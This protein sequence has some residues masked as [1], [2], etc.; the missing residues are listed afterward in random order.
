VGWGFFLAAFAAFFRFGWARRLA[1]FAVNVP[2]G[3]SQLFDALPFAQQVD[4]H[5]GQQQR[6]GFPRPSRRDPGD[7]QQ[8]SQHP[9]SGDDAHRQRHAAVALCHR[10]SAQRSFR[11]V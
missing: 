11:G 9:Q 5:G 8:G 4:D 10:W 3:V 1:E 2:N 6:R 7:I